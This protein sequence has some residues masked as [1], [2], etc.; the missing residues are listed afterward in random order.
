MRQLCRGA[1]KHANEVKRA[2]SYRGAYT[3]QKDG[4]IRPREDH[5]RTKPLETWERGREMPPRRRKRRRRR[6]HRHRRKVRRIGDPM[7]SAAADFDIARV[8]LKVSKDKGGS[9]LGRGN[10]L[11]GQRKVSPAP[12]SGREDS[13]GIAADKPRAA[14]KLQAEEKWWEENLRKP[15][16]HLLATV[17][18]RDPDGQDMTDVREKQFYG[19]SEESIT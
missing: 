9:V 5:T 17:Q 14:D 13:E 11:R 15:V 18:G 12:A 19:L 10:M 7:R 6:R 1:S 8:E 16:G 2:N 4:S 3:T